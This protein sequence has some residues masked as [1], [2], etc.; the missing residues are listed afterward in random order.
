MQLQLQRRGDSLL[1]HSCIPAPADGGRCRIRIADDW[2]EQS[3]ILTPQAV[4]LWEVEHADSLTEAHFQRLAELDAEVVILGLGRHAAVVHAAL[5][6]PLMRRRIGLETMDTAA[7]CRTYNIL[8][9][10]GRRAAAALIA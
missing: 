3:L 10:D 4:A 8:A 7:A 6:R 9:S 1:I 5:A 2:Y